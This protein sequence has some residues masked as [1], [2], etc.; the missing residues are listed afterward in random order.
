MFVFKAFFWW[1][2]GWC[3]GWC[4]AVEWWCVEEAVEDLFVVVV[5]FVPLG[6]FFAEFFAF[7]FSAGVFSEEFFEAFAFFFVFLL[8]VFVLCF[9]VLVCVEFVEDFE[10]VL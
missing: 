2:V 8:H 10:L 1:H 5:P 6:D 3:G 7:T 9:V 4:I